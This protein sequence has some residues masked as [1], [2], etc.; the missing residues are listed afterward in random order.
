VWLNAICHLIQLFHQLSPGHPLAF[1][2]GPFLLFLRILSP[3]TLHCLTY[4]TSRPTN[5]NVSDSHSNSKTRGW[6]IPLNIKFTSMVWNQDWTHWYT[7][8]LRMFQSGA[9]TGII[10]SIKLLK[11]PVHSYSSASGHWSKEGAQRGTEHGAGHTWLHLQPLLHR[12][13][14]LAPKTAPLRGH[15]HRTR[16]VRRST[17]HSRTCILRYIFF[18]LS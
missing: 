10:F 8:D 13:E 3:N 6:Y 14:L 7:W 5:V 11:E 17:T 15:C 16:K 1:L 18:Y 2:P 12:E 9:D 4:N